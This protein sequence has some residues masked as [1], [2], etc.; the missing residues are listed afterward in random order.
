MV[1][2]GG[3]QC[4]SSQLLLTRWGPGEAASEPQALSEQV[5]LGAGEMLVST[6]V[7]PGR[8][9]SALSGPTLNP[10]PLL[11]P[12]HAQSSPV[13]SWGGARTLGSRDS[14]GSRGSARGATA[15]T[16]G[17]GVGELPSVRGQET[18]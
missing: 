16:M 8:P 10:T 11:P 13:C 2:R 5:Y 18:G 17:V 6:G 3:L 1:G 7:F 15:L 9:L 4:P 12:P 14:T